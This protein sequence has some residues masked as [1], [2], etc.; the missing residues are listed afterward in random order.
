MHFFQATERSSFD[1]ARSLDYIPKWVYRFRMQLHNL[2]SVLRNHPGTSPRFVLPDGDYIPAHAHVTEVGHSV[3]NFIDCGGVAGKFEAV[4]LQTHVGDEIEHRP[5]SA[6]F[7][8]ILQI[9][10]R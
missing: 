9:V 4:L 3:K 2:K 5:T 6:S 7:S 1:V 10:T 8:K